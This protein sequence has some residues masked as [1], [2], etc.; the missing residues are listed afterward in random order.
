MKK[1]ILI[2]FLLT[3]SVIAIEQ[4]TF[5]FL[6]DSLTEGYGVNK[7]D[8]FPTLIYN[9][10]KLEN[11]DV[12]VIQSG[13]AG[14]TSASGVSRL[15]WHLKNKLTHVAIALGSNDGLRG[16]KVEELKKNLE[17][18]ILLAKKYNLKILLLGAKVPPNYNQ[19]YSKDFENVYF[20]LAKKYSLVVVPFILDGV[21]GNPKLNQADGIHPNTLGHEI[22]AKKLYPYILKVL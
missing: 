18:V 5:L 22:I 15:K 20:N 3:S 21:A 9:R 16:L 11:R 8:S 4:K 14:A 13:V 1:F 19:Q 10:L 6:G 7:D 12:V 2:F 17:E